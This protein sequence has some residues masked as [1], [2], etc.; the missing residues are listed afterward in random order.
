M[1]HVLSHT[2]YTTYLHKKLSVVRPYSPPTVCLVRTNMFYQIRQH[3]KTVTTKT[4]LLTSDEY[5]LQCTTATL[6]LSLFS[7]AVTPMWD[8]LSKFCLLFLTNESGSPP[9]GISITFASI[10]LSLGTE[11]RPSISKRQAS[12]KKGTIRNCLAILTFLSR[13][14]P[15]PSLLGNVLTP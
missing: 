4:N 3:S 10:P 15:H 11:T 7:L 14:S 9:G 12:I 2:V 13:V 8:A 1:L 5:P 6:W